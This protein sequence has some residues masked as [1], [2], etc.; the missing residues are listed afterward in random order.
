M[1]V[2]AR[3]RVRRVFQ[4][5]RAERRTIRQGFVALVI[6]DLGSLV[7]GIALGAITH[8]LRA[9]PGLL[10]MIPAA[11]GMRGNIFGAL[12]SRLATSIHAGVYRPTWTRSGVLSQNVYAVS[13]LTFVISLFLGVLAKTLSVAFGLNSIS[14]AD[15]IAISVI[16]GVISSVVVGAFTVALSGM[17]YRRR[18]D[19]DSVAAPLITGSGDMVTTPALFLASYLVEVPKLS[20]VISLLALAT[21]IVLGIRSLITDLQITR[22]VVRESIPILMLAG[23]V[24]I[25]A[26][27]LIEARLDKF[28]VYPALLVLVPPFLE[29][30]GA[31][32]G[33]LSARLASKLHMGLITPRGKPEPAAVLDASV[34]F[35]FAFRSFIVVGILASFTSFIFGLASPGV[36]TM[37]GISLTAGAMATVLA[38]VVAYYTAV[39]T[40]RIGLDPDNHGVA[41][42]TSSMDLLGVLCIVVTLLIFGIA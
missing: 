14:L 6:A 5:W 38:V 35:L 31:L 8:R 3:R 39:A 11:I 22:R 25:L 10:V 28:L 30:A 20:V 33:I 13:A 27:L 37:I 15:F 4:H 18:W 36:L 24:D 7:A 2:H 41:V 9:L 16:G 29:S 17:A 23:S 1:R 12:G 21:A 32:G 42:I 40:F 26:G 19:L 34:I